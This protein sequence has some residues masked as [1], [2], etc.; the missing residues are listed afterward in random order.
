MLEY[1][2]NEQLG[3]LAAM[4]R[5][6]RCDRFFASLAV[7]VLVQTAEASAAEPASVAAG[8]DRSPANDL[9]RS[10]SINFPAFAFPD[11]YAPPQEPET[12]SFSAK[13][14]RPLGFTAKNSESPP[15]VADDSLMRE[16]SVW[17]R[18][19]DFRALGRVRVLTLWQTSASSVSLQAGKRGNPSLQWTAKLSDHSPGSS[20]LFDRLTSVSSAGVSHEIRGAAH[21]TAPAPAPAIKSTAAPGSAHP[22]A[23]TMP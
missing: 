23:A 7:L 8:S 22:A 2:A 10:P 1:R 19:A 13:Y 6:V 11:K 14:F 18:L 16:T 3:P 5:R 9:L 20:G 17:Q 15:I 21:P 12:A 4:P